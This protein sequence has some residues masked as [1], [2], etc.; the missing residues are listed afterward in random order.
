[1]S[2]E[3]GL[4]LQCHIEC[5]ELGTPEARSPAASRGHSVKCEGASGVE[6]ESPQLRS[7]PELAKTCRGSWGWWLRSGPGDIAWGSEDILSNGSPETF[8]G[9]KHWAQ[10]YSLSLQC[11]SASQSLLHARQALPLGYTLCRRHLFPIY[12]HW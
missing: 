1:V 5:Q 3:G 4:P 10:R 6:Q 11:C 9:Q 2:C 7:W 8:S 12:N